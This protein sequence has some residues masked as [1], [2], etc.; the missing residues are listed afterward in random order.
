MATGYFG[1]AR[2]Q[3]YLVDANNGSYK[4]IWA[5]DTLGFFSYCWSPK[6]DKIAILTNTSKYALT[7]SRSTKVI[8]HNVTSGKTTALPNTTKGPKDCVQWSPNGKW[9]AWAGREGD[10]ST[11]STENLEIYIASATKGNAKSITSGI[12][13]CL[14]AV[15]ISDTGEIAFGAQLLWSGDSKNLLVKIGWHGEEQICT[16]PKTGGKLKPLTS[17][18]AIHSMGN[19]AS[20]GKT[21]SMMVASA[22]APPE[23]YLAKLSS[24]TISLKQ[25]SFENTTVV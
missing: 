5:K 22:I 25:F 4:N 1:H 16:I 13:R 18:N 7:D 2:F 6:G 23:I 12:D 11:Y 19:F 20:D 3:L 10:E 15:T 8:I 21:L 24:S 9:L 17:G 14:M